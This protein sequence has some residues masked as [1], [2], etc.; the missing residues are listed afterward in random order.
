MDRP[1][2]A[3]EAQS[4]SELIA[5]EVDVAVLP[6][7]EAAT[8]APGQVYQYDGTDH[9]WI[10]YTSGFAAPAYAICREPAKTITVDTNVL[11]IVAG[12]VNKSKLDATAQA[13]PDIRNALLKS[14]III[15]DL[16][17]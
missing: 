15:R 2:I 5:G 16:Q 12:Y 11:C 13:D 1:S 3:N 10:N 7:D 9:N 14:Q 6:V 8:V 4:Y 17:V